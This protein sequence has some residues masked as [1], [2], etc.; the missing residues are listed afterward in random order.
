MNEI[1]D[2]KS[3]GQNESKI[4]DSRGVLRYIVI[5]IT[6]TLILTVTLWAADLQQNKLGLKI[7]IKL[8]FKYKYF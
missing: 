7:G 1:D 5:I 2:N 6:H 3:L 8:K 4:L